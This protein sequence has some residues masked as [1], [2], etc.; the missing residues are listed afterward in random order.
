MKY[1]YR[2]FPYST[3]DIQAAQDELNRLGAAGWKLDHLWLDEIARYVR[4]DRPV[5]YCVD[6]C[7]AQFDENDDYLQLC[8]DAGWTFV[9]KRGYWNIY[10]APVGTPPIQTDSALEYERFQKQVW[11]QMKKGMI[12]SVVL[13]ALL[14]AAFLFLVTQEQMLNAETLL[15]WL[16]MNPVLLPSIFFVLAGELASLLRFFCQW[17]GLRKTASDGEPLPVPGRGSVFWGKFLHFWRV[18]F[19]AMVVVSMIHKACKDGFSQILFFVAV[20]LV[21]GIWFWRRPFSTAGQR[22]TAKAFM[23]AAV[24]TLLYW[25]LL[26]PAVSSWETPGPAIPSLLTDDPQQVAAQSPGD[27][28]TLRYNHKEDKGFLINYTSWNET[29]GQDQASLSCY[30]SRS[31]ELARIAFRYEM[32]SEPGMKPVEGREDLWQLEEHW[33]EDTVHTVYLLRE[34]NGVV[35]AELFTVGPVED[36]LKTDVIRR[37][38]HCLDE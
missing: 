10:E 25:L 11:K 6:W 17:R 26:F 18:I 5:S 33:R 37:M 14:A 31:A 9:A 2:F 16:G 23:G 35:K 19:G 21:I 4:T 28:D 1:S 12:W 34:E 13:L 29:D 3:M 20:W 7:D 22:R 27:A 8:A 32:E 30:R 15:L 36:A 24:V 38:E